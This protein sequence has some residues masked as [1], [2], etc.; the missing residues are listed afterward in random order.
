LRKYGNR[1]LAEYQCR[2]NRRQNLKTFLP[3]L[4]RAAAQPTTRTRVWLRLA[5]YSC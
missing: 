4:L 5:E 2:F 1:Y 3:R